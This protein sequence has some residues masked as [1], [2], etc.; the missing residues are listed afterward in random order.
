MNKN[1]QR[2]KKNTSSIIVSLANIIFIFFILFF[3][4]LLFYWFYKL[5]NLKGTDVPLI[6]IINILLSF[7]FA[8]LFGFGLKIIKNDMKINLSLL[9]FSIFISIYSFEIYLEFFQKNQR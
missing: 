4:S 7:T 8:A 9:L 6:Y 1:H 5:Y 2:S 3:T